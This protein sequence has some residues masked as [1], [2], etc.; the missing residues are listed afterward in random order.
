MVL[1]CYVLNLSKK[2]NYSCENKIF[3]KRLQKP[4]IFKKKYV[5]NAVIVLTYQNYD[6]NF[7]HTEYSRK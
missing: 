2:Q 5:T 7:L 4:V 1:E 6:N 3:K